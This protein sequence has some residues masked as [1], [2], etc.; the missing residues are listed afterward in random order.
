MS[1]NGDMNGWIRQAMTPKHALEAFVGLLAGRDPADDAQGR[2]ETAQAAQQGQQGG[3]GS[4]TGTQGH[5]EGQT[6]TR[7][8]VDANAGEG[9]RPENQPDA[10][11]TSHQAMNRLLKEAVR[12]KDRG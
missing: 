4:G 12:N 3:Q 2:Q 1:T 11:G 9:N 10:G 7:R 5:Q 6:P 8:R